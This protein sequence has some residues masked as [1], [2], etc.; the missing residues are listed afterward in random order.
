MTPDPES[1]KSRPGV[2]AGPSTVPH[3]YD[4][5]IVGSGFGGSVC[6]LRLSEK[7]YKVAVLESGKRRAD[8][9]YAASTWNL[10]D[11]LWAP[12]LGLHGILNLTRFADIFIASGAGVGGGSTVYA[13]TLYRAKPEFFENP[14]WK[15]LADW[16]SVLQPHYDVAERMLGVERVPHESSGQR[17]LLEVGAA[18]DC[19]QTFTR[20]PVGVFFGAPGREVPDPYFGGEGPARTGCTR[21]G[22][23]MVGCRVG[24]KNTLLKNYLWFAERRGATVIPERE[25]VEIRP[26]GDGTG[27][28]GYAVTT[29]RPGAWLAKDRRTFTA[30]GVIVSAGALGTN[31][32]LLKCKVCGALPRLSDRLGELV[33]TNSESILAISLPDDASQPWFDVAISASLH[34][35]HDTHIE[36]CTYGQHGDFMSLLL[37]PLTGK[38]SRATRP[39]KLIGAILRHPLRA[40]RGLS[41]FG[42]SRRSLV[43]LVMQTS[44]NAIA[45]RSSHGLLG[46]RLRTE[47]N[48]DKPN[49]TFIP[50][51]NAIA[52]WLAEHTGGTA[53]S[54]VFEA[55][56]NIPTTAHILGGAAIG[57]DP[58]RGVVDARLRAFGYEN[59]MVVDGS[60]M[61]ANPGVNPSLSITALAEYAMAQVPMAGDTGH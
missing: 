30:K 4:W 49:P 41:P 52:E 57:A 22:A 6:A 44:D 40:L 12:V 53:H 34:P 14:Q 8:D 21:C 58:S 16:A 17:L 31:R 29:Q 35:D 33:R 28:N 2:D 15:G 9:Q 20:T 23:C 38:G 56:M 51:A 39:I 1:A 24:A 11:Y 60:T 19:A 13:N 55:T 59:L 10:R 47:Q 7:G 45:F 36:F 27:R 18:F 61:P 5:L 48:A 50:V 3:E 26:L 43:L 42:W 25:V 54:S 32:L 46:F 37:A